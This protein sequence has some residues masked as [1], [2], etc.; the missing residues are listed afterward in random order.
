MF[1]WLA[2][3]VYIIVFV[4]RAI[5]AQYRRWVLNE[6]IG[7][8]PVNQEERHPQ[9]RQHGQAV[10]MWSWKQSTRL[11]A[12]SFGFGI[13]LGIIQWQVHGDWCQLALMGVVLVLLNVLTINFPD[14]WPCLLGEKDS[15]ELLAARR[16][17]E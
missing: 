16:P 17:T 5:D 6:I 15:Y 2:A 3:Y 12:Q 1:L 9:A 14:L 10:A 11:A 8:H 7:D 13:V 4:L